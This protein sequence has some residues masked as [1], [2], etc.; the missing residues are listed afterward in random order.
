MMGTLLRVAAMT[1]AAG[2]GLVAA[3]LLGAVV[4]SHRAERRQR[5]LDRLVID[6]CEHLDDELAELLGE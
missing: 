5:A 4:G 3:G 1:Y 2:V 6:E